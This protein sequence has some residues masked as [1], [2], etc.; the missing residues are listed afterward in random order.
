MNPCLLGNRLT[1]THQCPWW[2]SQALLVV[3]NQF[4]DFRSHWMAL[5]VKLSTVFL[6]SLLQ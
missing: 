1:V 5:R 4:G 2:P 3:A 6:Q